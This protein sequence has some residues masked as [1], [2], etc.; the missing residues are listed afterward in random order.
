MGKPRKDVIKYLAG[1]D[2]YTMHRP[3]CRRFP[4]QRTYS[5]GIDDLFQ[6]DLADM[7]NMSAYND[8]YR[9]LL[10]CIDVFTLLLL[11]F[12]SFSTIRA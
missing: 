7:S 5:K 6:I 1:Q 4:R 11:L 10:N 9:Y 2:A 8:G 12:S 3:T